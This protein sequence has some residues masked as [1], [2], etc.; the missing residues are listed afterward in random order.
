MRALLDGVLVG[1][2]TVL[3]DNPQLTVRHVEGPNPR[4]LVLSG[5]GTALRGQQP[6]QIFES[7]G[8]V[9]IVRSDAEVG[10]TNDH[11][12]VVSLQHNGTIGLPPASVL[13]ALSERG[14]HS[15]YLEGG[16]KTVSSFLGAS[17]IDILQVH[18]ASMVLGSGL[19]SFS[20]PEVEHVRDGRP[21]VMDH[22]SLQGHLLLTCWPQ[23]MNS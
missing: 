11:V 21:M 3:Q 13:E 12:E 20:L 5:T 6:R 18:I 10:R 22:V 9:V 8:S 14:I 4:R 1:A 15:I 7:P 23:P 16:A 19:S 17:A 2:R